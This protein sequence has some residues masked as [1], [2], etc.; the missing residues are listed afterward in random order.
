MSTGR[1][2]A[3]AKPRPKLFVNTQPFDHSFFQV[4]KFTA[5]TL[6]QDSS[7]LRESD[8]VLKFDDL[9]EKL[10]VKS[11]DSQCLGELYGKRKRKEENVSILLESLFVR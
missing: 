11:M 8:G 10:K 4:L 1:L 9:I 5:R 3:K 7:I 6:R 2:V